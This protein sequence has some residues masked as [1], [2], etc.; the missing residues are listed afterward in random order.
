MP[1]PIHFT[2]SFYFQL[3]LSLKLFIPMTNSKYVESICV[4]AN[5]TV[6][7]FNLKYDQSL[8]E[9]LQEKFQGIN[10][11]GDDSKYSGVG[12]S[13]NNVQLNRI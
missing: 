7:E 2:F 9:A 12:I 10:I 11:F 8:T 1:L 3:P 4:Q 5:F 13:M 6:I